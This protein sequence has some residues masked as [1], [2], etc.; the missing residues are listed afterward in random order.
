MQK[1][2]LGFSNLKDFYTWSIIFILFFYH[3]LILQ[4]HPV[5]IQMHQ[6]TSSLRN[7]ADKCNKDLNIIDKRI[8]KNC[9]IFQEIPLEEEWR[10]PFLNELISAKNNK[11][12][13]NGVDQAEIDDI[14]NFICTT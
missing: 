3:I 4:S 7:I 9:M 1:N 6:Q 2:M 8:V 10:I 12:V 11:I 13:I 5:I 14:I